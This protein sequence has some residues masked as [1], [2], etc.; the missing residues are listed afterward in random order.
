MKFIWILRYGFMCVHF[1]TANLFCRWRVRRKTQ[2]PSSLSRLSYGEHSN[3]WISIMCLR[4]G[5]FALLLYPNFW[6]WS[7]FCFSAPSGPCW[8]QSRIIF[9]TWWFRSALHR[10]GK[11]FSAVQ[12]LLTSSGNDALCNRMFSFLT[13]SVVRPEDVLFS[14]LQCCS[15]H[16]ETQRC[17]K[18]VMCKKICWT[19]NGLLLI[20]GCYFDPKCEYWCFSLAFVVRSFVSKNDQLMSIY[21]LTVTVMDTA[22]LDT[23]A[24]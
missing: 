19:V 13:G 16:S 23:K 2:S 18:R 22:D 8:L 20:S 17:A 24:L 1:I 9:S 3:M 14:K 6:C 4:L 11:A 12:F 7:C 5:I 10:L 21:Y 15:L